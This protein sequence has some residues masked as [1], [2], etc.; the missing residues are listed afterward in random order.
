V[1]NLEDGIKSLAGFTGRNLMD[2]EIN[3]S[4]FTTKKY[5]AWANA[6]NPHSWVVTASDPYYGVEIRS[7][8]IL[9]TVSIAAGYEVNRVTRANG[10]YVNAVFG[11]WFPQFDVGFSNLRQEVKLDDGTEASSVNN[12]LSAGVALPLVFSPGVYY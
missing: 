1:V 8:N 9:N 10:P 12:K 2:E 5:S 3:V 7:N 6:I 11:M 4:D